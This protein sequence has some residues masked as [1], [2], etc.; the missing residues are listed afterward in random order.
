VFLGKCYDLI[1]I[2]NRKVYKLLFNMYGQMNDETGVVEEVMRLFKLEGDKYA[3]VIPLRESL[4][5]KLPFEL[6]VKFFS[7]MGKNP[8]LTEKELNE[9]F[10]TLMHP[11]GN[12]LSAD[13]ETKLVAPYSDFVE[14]IGTKPEF[15]KFFLRYG[16]GLSRNFHNKQ[17][18]VDLR[19]D[20]AVYTGNGVLIEVSFSPSCWN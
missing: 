6:K 9:Y 19:G 3:R 16:G 20:L 8:L 7:Q 10:G 14:D 15:F 1:V 18:G 11:G 12:P 13:S 4:I 2:N 17:T 5:A